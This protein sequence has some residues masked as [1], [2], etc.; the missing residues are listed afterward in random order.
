MFFVLTSTQQDTMLKC[1]CVPSFWLHGGRSKYL[2]FVP[3]S[4]HYLISSWRN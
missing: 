1:L 3:P 4:D 2:Q